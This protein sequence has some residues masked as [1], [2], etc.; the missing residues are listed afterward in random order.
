MRLTASE[1]AA[2]K[3]LTPRAVRF[4]LQKGKLPGRK[5]IDPET[6]VETWYVELSSA[7]ET[8]TDPSASHGNSVPSLTETLSTLQRQHQEEMARLHRENLEL[9]GRL[10]FYQARIQELERRILEL[11]APKAAPTILEQN[12]HHS[13]AGAIAEESNGP[14]HAE[15]GQTS[16]SAGSAGSAGALRRL[17][18]WLTQPV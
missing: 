18:R 14:P 12:A 11:E 6:G 4:Q 2:R 8:I 10:G 9:A 15:N 5:E 17:W 13:T 16:R 1:Y 7:G 3:G